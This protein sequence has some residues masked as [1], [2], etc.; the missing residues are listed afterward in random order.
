[1]HV[2]VSVLA[3]YHEFPPD[4]FTNSQR[5][6]GA[7]VVHLLVLIY[8]FVALAIV[9]DFYFVASLEKICEVSMTGHFLNN[10]SG[11]IWQKKITSSD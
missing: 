1:M 2:C 3:A 11:Q 5:K 8:M 4:A 10:H 7:I 9:C 6:S